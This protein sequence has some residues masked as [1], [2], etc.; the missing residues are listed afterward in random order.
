MVV[1]EEEEEE[2]EEEDEGN[3]EDETCS[4]FLCPAAGAGTGRTSMASWE[5]DRERTLSSSSRASE[6]AEEME[7]VPP[8]K[9]GG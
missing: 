8:G 1:E 6:A 3:V 4:F 2:E 5:L 9:K 7:R